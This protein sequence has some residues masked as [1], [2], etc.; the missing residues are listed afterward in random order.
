M[1]SFG[2]S[3]TLLVHLYSMSPEGTINSLLKPINRSLPSSFSLFYPLNVA[4]IHPTW[5]HPSLPHSSSRSLSLYLSL[6]S[7]NLNHFMCTSLSGISVRFF[8][9][10]QTLPCWR[11]GSFSRR[12][13]K[14]SRFSKA[15]NR[16]ARGGCLI[17]GQISRLDCVLTVLPSILYTR[18]DKGDNEKS[19][20][21]NHRL[22][23]TGRY[24]VLR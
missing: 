20:W 15:D 3:S 11:S 16:Q 4:H 17:D 8:L 24:T 5:N 7:A 23:G 10:K 21:W 9:T 6:I 22:L 19:S 14:A 1:C 13:W 2:P 18:E 12:T